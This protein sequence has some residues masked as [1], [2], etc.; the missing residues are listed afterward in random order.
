MILLWFTILESYDVLNLSQFLLFWGIVFLITTTLIATPKK[1]KH[2]S[3]AVSSTVT[4]EVTAD[5]DAEHE[6]PELDLIE[7]YKVV[8]KMLKHL[9]IQVMIFL[10]ITFSFGFSAAD[11]I[12]NLKMIQN[13]VPRDKITQLAIPMIPVKIFRIIN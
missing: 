1:E 12:T 11:A 4:P 7:T 6:Q 10:L 3:L 5:G 2:A 13:G 8:W 9:L